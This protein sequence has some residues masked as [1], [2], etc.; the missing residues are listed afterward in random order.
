MSM[1]PSLDAGGPSAPARRV[2]LHEHNNTPRNGALV[3]QLL[4]LAPRPCASPTLLYS[5]R[6]RAIVT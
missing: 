6:R 2:C 4:S 3:S 1:M 5:G